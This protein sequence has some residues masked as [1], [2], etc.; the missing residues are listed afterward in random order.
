MYGYQYATSLDQLTLDENNL[1]MNNAAS[2]ALAGGQFET[3]AYSI[4]EHG[5]GSHADIGTP[6]E[7]P[8]VLYDSENSQDLV[9]EIG[10]TNPDFNVGFSTNFRYKDLGLYLLI[11]YQHGGDIY[12][13][14]LQLMYYND[15]HGYL[16]SYAGL[17][18]DQNYAQNL[19]Y[20]SRPNSHFVEDG[21][22]MKL[23]EVAVTYDI[24]NPVD[25][26]DRIGLKLSGVN[27]LTVTDYTGWDPEVA[28]STNPT[29]FRLD[30]YAYPNFSTVL[31]TV[32]INF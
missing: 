6:S 5:Y 8:L 16:V 21:T 14:T 4:N 3:D 25:F 23:R 12:N 26:I 11:D 20:Q 22:F 18:K 7:S 19:Y 17:Q 10:D 30:E 1:V 15:L 29:N 28:I 32:T 31:T 13:Y 24:N 27:L 9:S 2:N